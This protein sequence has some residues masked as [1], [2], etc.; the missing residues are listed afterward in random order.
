[1]HNTN[2][3]EMLLCPFLWFMQTLKRGKL[4]VTLLFLCQSENVFFGGFWT[5]KFY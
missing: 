4:T 1:M 5:E 3:T 2:L